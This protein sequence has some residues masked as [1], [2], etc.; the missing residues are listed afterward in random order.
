MSVVD[1]FNG[2]NGTIVHKKEIQTMI[3]QATEQEQFSVVDRLQNVLLANPKDKA[4]KFKIARPAIEV[5]PS[6]F[7]PYLDY[8]TDKDNKIIGL[9]KAVSPAEIYQMITDKMIE[10]IKQANDKDYKK[11]WSAKAYGK[12]YTL[13]FNFVTKKMYRGVNRF[14]LTGF[15][16][17]ENPFFLTFKQVN[18]LK[19]KVKKGSVGYEVVYFTQLY[20]YQD[21]KKK[22]DISSYDKAKFV[23]MLASKGIAIDDPDDFSLPILKYYKVFNGKD[24]EGIDFDLANFKKGYIDK[25]IPAID[26]NRLP[27]AEAIIKHYPTPQPKIFYGGDQAY[28]NSGTD[29]VQMP[30]LSDFDTAQ[31]FY[32]TM[33]HELSH[34][35][36]HRSRLERKLGNTF[37]SK[38]YAFEELIAEFGA[39]FLSAEAGIIWHTNKNHAAYLKNWNRVLVHLQD[40]NRF[41][42]RAA[43]QAQKVADFVLQYDSAGD[44]KYFEEFKKVTKAKK[45]KAKTPKTD[46]K[47]EITGSE[48][49][50]KP[51]VT[52]R[53]KPKQESRQLTLALNGRRKQNKV[54]GLGFINPVTE[55]EPIVQEVKEDSQS[56]EEIATPIPDPIVQTVIPTI[57]K[58]P[59]VQNIGNAGQ[60][61]PSQFFTVAGEVG[62]FLQRVERKAVESVVITMDGEQGAGKTTTLYKFIDAF[63]TPG[64]SCLFISG[65]EHPDSELA[66]KKRDEYLSPEAIA[67]TDIVAAVNSKVQLYDLI[68]DYDIIF[69]DSWQKLLRMVG[70]IQLDEELRKKFNGKVFVIIFQ[71]TTT[72][73]TK[74]GA[75]VVF[76]GDI[77][78]KMVKESSF[79]DNYA[80]FDKNRYTLVPIE[81][82]RYN[83]A[84]GTVYDPEAKEEITQTEA[85]EKPELLFTVVS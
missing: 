68:E 4:L 33:F 15:E 49:N 83:I 18:D 8:E 73:R 56:I 63:A 23:A 20:L 45:A 55:P 32:R 41:L 74:G 76:D 12:G 82:I 62:K 84:T 65:E 39:T 34:S 35:T 66:T 24:I 5:V 50:K 16:P 81:T 53:R 26:E 44:P 59:L 72:G 40:D 70:N 13:P 9:G 67:N 46:T 54:T 1:K 75:E 51:V 14:L 6:S 38:D 57:K 19:G 21:T 47:K 30:H 78:I 60:G 2:L 43:T 58:N 64:N 27:V 37:G 22:I 3:I 71:Q 42:M 29:K 7:L 80:Y 61:R 17:L 77:I 36:G 69:I 25:E 11:K 31:D 79:A 85:K 28:Y 10:L 52:D 48:P